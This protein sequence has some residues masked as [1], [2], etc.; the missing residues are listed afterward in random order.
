MC[1]EKKTKNHKKT[2]VII[3]LRRLIDKQR[4]KKT[5]KTSFRK[6][7]IK[8][9][10]KLTFLMF[11]KKFFFIITFVLKIIKIKSCHFDLIG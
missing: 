3:F 9:E 6:C 8:N 2:S 7:F 1:D 4:T 5:L 10:N 11:K